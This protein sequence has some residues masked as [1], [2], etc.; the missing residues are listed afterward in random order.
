MKENKIRRERA[1][2]GRGKGRGGE[3]RIGTV[4]DTTKETVRA[5]QMNKRAIR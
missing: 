1:R 3:E 4:K 2:R 5:R